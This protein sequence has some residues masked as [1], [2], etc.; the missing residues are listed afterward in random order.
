M[1]QIAF[2]FRPQKGL[3]LQHKDQ[4]VRIQGDSSPEQYLTC[5]TVFIGVTHMLLLS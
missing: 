5:V 3:N 1:M 4:N 2:V